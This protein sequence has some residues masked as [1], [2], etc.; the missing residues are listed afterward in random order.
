M[1][2]SCWSCVG[3]G[4]RWEVEGGVD[5]GVEGGGVLGGGGGIKC[6]LMEWWRG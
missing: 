2:T 4:E 5:G 6:T 3:A 1:S